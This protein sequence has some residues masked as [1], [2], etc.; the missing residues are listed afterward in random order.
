MDLRSS[1]SLERLEN[2]A[3]ID[4]SIRIASQVNASTDDK[5]PDKIYQLGNLASFVW[6]RFN[7]DERPADLEEAVSLQ[8]YALEVTNNAA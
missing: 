8:K 6:S 1:C 4:E 3:D 7:L 2:G 5:Q